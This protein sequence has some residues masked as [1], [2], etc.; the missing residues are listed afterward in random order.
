VSADALDST[1]LLLRVLYDDGIIVYINGIET[2]RSPS[3]ASVNPVTNQT[4]AVNTEADSWEVVNIGNTNLVA[5]DNVI[6]IE[7]HQTSATSS[8]VVLGIVVEALTSDAVPPVRLNIRHVAVG[9]NPMGQVEVSWN[10]AAAAGYVL[11]ESAT[12]GGPWTP[13]AGNPQ[14]T[15]VTTPTAGATRFYQLRNP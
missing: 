7:L 13:V 3:I 8:D 14:G 12:V 4:F 10:A 15:Y 11:V 2:W 6:A 9:A 5:G 1:Q